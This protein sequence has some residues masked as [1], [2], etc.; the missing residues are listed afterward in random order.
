MEALLAGHF[1]AQ[2][3]YAAAA[4]AIPDL[5]ANGHVTIDD[6][7]SAAGCHSPSLLRLMRTL[8]SLGVLERQRRANSPSRRSAPR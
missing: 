1:V 7:A 8:S 2:A 6:L 4:L 5:I 3:L